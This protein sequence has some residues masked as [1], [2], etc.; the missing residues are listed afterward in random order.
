MIND[1]YKI[2][3]KIP[4]LVH[5]VLL[6][7]VS[8]FGISLNR[9][10]NDVFLGLY[11]Q[12]QE[13]WGLPGGEGKTLQFKLNR[14]GQNLF[15]FLVENHTGLFSNKAGYFRN[16]IMSYS[17][18]ASFKRERVVFAERL[19]LVE[20]AVKKKVRMAFR[21][22]DGIRIMEPY[23]VVTD[24]EQEFN[25]IFGWCVTHK[26]Y[27]NY[28]LSNIIP[29]RLLKVKQEHF[30]KAKAD[31]VKKHFDPFLSY[32]E[33]VTV[34][35]T[36]NGLYL[37]DNV[38]FLNQPRVLKRDGNVLVLES[39][40]KKAKVYLASFLDEAC[41]LAPPELRSYFLE[42]ARMMQ[43]IYREEAPYDQ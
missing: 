29:T 34:R 38:K 26:D 14:E 2:K 28:R 31:E 5:S 35:F 16:L 19:S 7:D 36:N 43:K 24:R 1:E 4:N 22:R 20:K 6:R 17:N 10:C 21:Y 39:S 42:K 27:R 8:L 25:Y 30:D 32:G 12:F 15:E 37:F 9:L 18:M 3:T 11:D 13:G 41:V 40:I 33:T 23:T